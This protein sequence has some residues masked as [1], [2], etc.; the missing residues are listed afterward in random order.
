VRAID[1][2]I[3]SLRTQRAICTL[4]AGGE[5]S[6]QK[7]TLMNDLA[8]LSAAE[9]QQMIDDFVD[10]TFAGT[11][12]EAPGAG[13]AGAMRTLPTELPDD[14]TTE[15][16]AAWLEL[17]ELVGDPAFRTRA[18]EMA[19]AG[20]TGDPTPPPT[21]A[22]AVLE[23]AGAA[24]AAGVDP[25]SPAGQQVLARIVGPDLE[26]SRRAEIADVLA[27]FSDRRVERYWQLLGVLNGWPE[28]P[29]SIPAFEWVIEALRAG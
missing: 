13:I 27:T 2:R 25:G 9:R 5:W 12:P 29:A 28:R 3:R 1:D 20:S 8:K 23:H 11:D 17:A 16:V 18:R 10:A 22:S 19:V 24:L 4:L 15:Q 21:D 7:A 26:P 6:Q 14:P